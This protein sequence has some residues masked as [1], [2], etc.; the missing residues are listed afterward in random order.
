MSL[1]FV[2]LFTV[3]DQSAEAQGVD[4]KG[5]TPKVKLEELVTGHIVE[6]NGKY[7]FRA[8]EVRVAKTVSGL[9]LICAERVRTQTIAGV[10]SRAR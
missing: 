8:T 9:A 5:I 7:K 2:S 3:A 1:L 6:L 10:S 4:S